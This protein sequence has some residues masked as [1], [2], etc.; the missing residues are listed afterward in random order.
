MIK[1]EMKNYHMSLT[2]KQQKYQH[3]DCIDRT[4]KVL[5]LPSQLGIWKA[6]KYDWRSRRKNMKAFEKHGKQLVKY[7]NEKESSAHSKQKYILEEL[8]NGRMEEIWDLSRRI[9]FNNLIYCHNSGSA[10]KNFA[11]FKDPLAF[12][13]YKVRSYNTR[14]SWQKTKIN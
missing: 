5:T 2:E 7:K 9:D 1:L 12:I 10:S 6:N 8:T 13:K 11:G 4:I 14:K 3:Y